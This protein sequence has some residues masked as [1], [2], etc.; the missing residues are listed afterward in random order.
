MN[1]KR[2]IASI[3]IASLVIAGLTVGAPVAGAAAKV[4]VPNVVGQTS[5]Y[6]SKV[7]EA[8]KL[9]PLVVTPVKSASSATLE[10]QIKLPV[11]DEQSPKGGALALTGSKVSIRSYCFGTALG[12]SDVAVVPLSYLGSDKVVASCTDTVAT[13]D[14]FVRGWVGGVD[15]TSPIWRRIAT[16]PEITSASSFTATVGKAFSFKVTTSGYPAAKVYDSNGELTIFPAGVTFTNNGNGTA[17]ISGTPTV[18]GKFPIPITAGN[19]AGLGRT[20]AFT[21]TVDEAVAITS[22]EQYTAPEGTPFSF[23][24]TTT[25]YPYPQMIVDGALPAGITFVDNGKGTATLSGTPTVPGLFTIT[26]HVPGW[27]DEG[28]YDFYLT[29]VQAPTITSDAWDVVSAGTPFTFTV[30]TSGFPAPS[31][32]MTTTAVDPSSPG[33]PVEMPTGVTF[34]D[35]GNGSGTLSGTPEPPY[36]D[37]SA[38]Y[39]LSIVATNYLGVTSQVFTLDIEPGA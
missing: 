27:E 38:T 20:Q 35:N 34:V 9:S 12:D 1:I 39:T 17:T 8:H 31:L 30:S 15:Y 24:V 11:V 7:L 32:T 36:G 13:F 5:A 21:L 33:Y 37:G 2:R 6:A 28:N 18:D 26:I 4:A 22:A 16:V 19:V 10:V 29:V 25:G 14:Q 3:A 23:T